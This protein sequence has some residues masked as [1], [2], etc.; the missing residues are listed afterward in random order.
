M[1]N[2]IKTNRFN[3]SNMISSR[4]LSLCVLA[5]V[6]ACSVAAVAQR[7]APAVRIVS[8]ID[9]GQ[10]VTLHGS[11]NFSAIGATDRGQVSADLPM[12][13]LTL[14]L[15]RSAEQQAAF[16]AFVAS[17]YDASSPSFHQW[18]TPAQI[19]DQFGPAPAD[20]AIVSGWLAGKGFAV[21]TVSPDRMTIAFSGTASQVENAFHT[22]IHNLSVD[23][24][25]HIANIADPQ[26]PSALAP[27]VG[28]VK[29]LHNFLPHPLHRMGSQVKLSSDAHGWVKLQNSSV[30]GTTAGA[31][32]A[33][34]LAALG[35]PGSSPKPNFYFPFTGTTA[36]EEDVAPYDFAAIYN[37]LPAWNNNTTGSGQTI[38]IIGTSDINLND[39]SSFK[40]AFGLPAGTTPVIAHGP[41]GDPNNC[42]QNSPNDACNG[43][44]VD[45]NSLDVEWSGAV[46]PGAQIVLVT[47]AYNSQSAPTNDPIFDGAQWVV[48]NAYVAGSAVH[49]ARIMSLSYGQCELFDGTAGNVA[50]NNLWQTAAAEGIAVF[51]ATGDSGAPACDQ[52]GDGIGN[53][54][55]AQYGLIVN[56]LASSQYDTAVGGTDFSWCQ[57]SYDS[58]GNFQGCSSSNASA[59]WNTSNSSTTQAAAKAYVPETPWNDTCEDPIWAKY[60]ESI[61]PLVNAS[62]VS[63]PEEACNFVYN[64]SLGLYFQGGDPPLMGL[65]DTVGGGGGASNCVV[66]S[67]TSSTL[68]SCGAGDTSTGTGFGNLTLVNDG[69]PKPSWQTSAAGLGV[70]ADG[71]RD[72]PDISFFAGDGS[73]DTGT[74]I[75]VSNDNATCASITA[76]NTDSTGGAEEI[77]GTSVAT[78]EM[79][80]VMALINQKA[81]AAQGNPNSA[82]YAIAAKQTY[83]SCS[84][85]SGSTSNGCY[86]NDVDQGT[87][88]MPC[89]Y[90]GNVVEGGAI[91]EGGGNWGQSA[92]ALGQA[93][94]NCS[95]IN[96]GDVVGTLSGNSAATGYDLASGLGSLNITNVVDA[97]GAWTATAGTKTATAAIN[98]GGVTSI[99]ASQSLSVTVTV[100]GTSG[101][102]TGN[103]TLS[104][105]ANGYSSTQTLSGGTATFTI[106]ANTFTSNGT[107]TLTAYYSGDGNYAAS[108]SSTAT[109]TVT[110][111]TAPP[112]GTFALA[113]ITSPAAIAPGSTASATA[114]VS[115]S[116][117]YAGTVTLSC[118]LMTEPSG[119]TNLPSCSPTGTITLSGTATSGNTTL[120]VTT[121]PATVETSRIAPADSRGLFGAGGGALLAL[122]VFFGIPARRRSWRAMLGMVALLVTLGS[123]AACGGGGSGTKTTTIP[124]TT[125]GAYTFTVTPQGNPAPASAAATQTFTVTVN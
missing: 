106:P 31:I 28:G 64:D 15:S 65:L 23:G 18:L 103:V 88:T 75:C 118:A 115:S 32:N 54:Y 19:G 49:G 105:S 83:A 42:G 74:L 125:A 107:V 37:L 34:A 81:G 124:G 50:Y 86:F 68:G 91:Y 93:S 100:S 112:T 57:P 102:P 27:V 6:F 58:K 109:F 11:L 76:T 7:V 2:M 101:T 123:L 85:E 62:G 80:G 4:S 26:I 17:Q 87:I 46:A 122:L 113:A 47:D 22:Q 73:K 41:D 8:A 95:I 78:P 3:R 67:T 12:T 20:I 29:G 59:Y 69:W 45:E 72:I 98:L 35:K 84:A 13:G 71:V 117:G 33:Q 38:A 97:S 79:A 39:V 55:A 70:P 92:G 43:G 30:A 60:L 16:N 90:Q 99:T 48:N 121:T 66:N 9:E 61:A 110:G 24:K 63:T 116:N 104:A 10:L 40:T 96:A 82:L 120:S 56:A 94:P 14:V 52:G 51:V 53:P 114:T 1:I 111:G 44:D 89:N 108:T 119:A 25:M 36:I 5:S 77:G 21:G